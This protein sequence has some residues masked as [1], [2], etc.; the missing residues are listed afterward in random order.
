MNKIEKFINLK[1]LML[2]IVVFLLFYFSSYFQIIPILLLNIDI[3][4]ITESQT[5]MLS[6]FSN[7]VLLLILYF[8]FR[9]E[10]KKEWQ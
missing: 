5:V 6:A 1:G 2:G 4:K 10:I 3:Q 8:I 9:K 7:T